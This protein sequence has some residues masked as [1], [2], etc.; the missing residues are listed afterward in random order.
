MDVTFLEE[1]VFYPKPNIQH[2]S[3]KDIKF[4]NHIMKSKSIQHQTTSNLS[5]VTQI[6]TTYAATPNDTPILYNNL[7]DNMQGKDSQNLEPN[8][9]TTKKYMEKDSPMPSSNIKPPLQLHKGKRLKNVQNTS[10]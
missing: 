6:E 9:S 8:I 2:E 7:K 4:G 10:I 5:Y 1:Q 3:S